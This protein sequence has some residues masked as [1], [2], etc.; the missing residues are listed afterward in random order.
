M[1]KLLVLALLLA[2]L[3]TGCGGGDSSGRT[4]N[5]V[6]GQKVTGQAATGQTAGDVA[7]QAQEDEWGLVLAA[8]DVTDTGLT[9]R[10]VQSGGNPS[11]EL[12]T[13]SLYWLE[14][15]TGDGWEKMEPLIEDLAWTTEAYLIAMDDE[16]EMAVDWTALYGQ[17]PPGSYRLGKSVM[18]FRD[19]G[20][21]GDYDEKDYYAAFSLT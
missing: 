16:T 9:L 4:E 18:D 17:L 13:G 2:L 10:F 20:D 11:G 5:D 15:E 7:A 3:L 6:S 1:E 19:P 14:R 8:E 21:Y 12:E